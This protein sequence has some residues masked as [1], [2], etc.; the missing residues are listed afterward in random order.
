M[1]LSL[2]ILGPL[3]L[4]PGSDSGSASSSNSSNSSSS[5]YLSSSCILLLIF[6]FPSLIPSGATQS[7]IIHHRDN[8]KKFIKRGGEVLSDLSD[9]TTTSS[10]S[11]S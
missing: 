10:S 6:I 4:L 5:S 7:I 8:F 1:G 3:G 2:S 9:L 11:L